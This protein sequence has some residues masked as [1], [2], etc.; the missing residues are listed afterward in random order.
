MGRKVSR[1]NICL[2]ITGCIHPNTE[3][4]YLFLKST[5]DRCRQY[6]ESIEYYIEKTSAAKIVFCEN[7]NYIYENKGMLYQKADSCG[8]SFEWIS[9]QGDSDRVVKQGKGYGEGEIIAY[10]LANSV[11]MKGADVFVKITGRLIV[12]NLDHIL[13][14]LSEE[15]NYFNSDI[16]RPRGIDTRFYCVTKKFYEGKLL[17]AYLDLTEEEGRLYALEDAF[18][19][20][21]ENEKIHC[22]PEYPM[23]CGISGGNGQNYSMMSKGVLTIYNFLCKTGIFNLIYPRYRKVKKYIRNWSKQHAD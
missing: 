16:Y 3:Q 2:L 5:E 7:S 1:D 22:L 6:I 19:D 17:S 9:F 14:N 11:L 13:K 4:K 15:A 20:I 10:A 21:L 23:I 8:K 18:F 12:C